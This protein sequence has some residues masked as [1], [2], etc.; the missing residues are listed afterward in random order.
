M[1]L[2]LDTNNRQQTIEKVDCNG[3]G[4]EL[5]DWEVKPCHETNK[6]ETDDQ[7]AWCS[8]CYDRWYAPVEEWL[9]SR[10][11]AAYSDLH[12]LSMDFSNVA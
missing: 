9:A 1:T 2:R 3:C 4:V 12:Y 7:G 5:E 6:S 11:A 8:G 10:E